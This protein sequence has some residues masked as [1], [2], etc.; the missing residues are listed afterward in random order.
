MIASEFGSARQ[1]SWI[2]TSFL[3]TS[4]GQSSRE[5]MWPPNSN[6]RL[7]A[8]S[9][10]YGRLSDVFGRKQVFMVAQTIFLGGTALCG[11]AP[12][13]IALIIGR[14]IAGQLTLLRAR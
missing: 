5:K 12:N 10:L 2:G 3:L 8:C 9:P 13:M 6:S 7:T 4:T 1:L 11:G 14:A